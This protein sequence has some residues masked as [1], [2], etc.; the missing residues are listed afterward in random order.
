MSSPENQN[1][2]I[3]RKYIVQ[4][5]AFW[6]G[7]VFYYIYENKDSLYPV[8]VYSEFFRLIDGSISKYWK[9]TFDESSLNGSNFY[10]LF[11]EWSENLG[12]YEDLINGNFFA[13]EI[14]SKYRGL[15]DIENDIHW[16]HVCYLLINGLD[17][18]ISEP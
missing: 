17:I 14:F 12:I 16:F 11:R 10:L 6:E 7:K 3:G 2:E 13:M 4:G 15:L 18:F 1:I 9:A 5:L 8:P